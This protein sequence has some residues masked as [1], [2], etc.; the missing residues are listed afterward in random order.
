MT[1]SIRFFLSAGT[2]ILVFLAINAAYYWEGREPNKTLVGATA[3]V[4]AVGAWH[5]LRYRKKS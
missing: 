1:D 3:A 5:Y 2:G 4:A